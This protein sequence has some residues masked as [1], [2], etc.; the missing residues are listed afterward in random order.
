MEVHRKLAK[1]VVGETQVGKRESKGPGKVLCGFRWKKRNISELSS[2]FSCDVVLGC[3]CHGLC[4]E[5]S[6]T[7]AQCKRSTQS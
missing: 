3:L 1:A 6:S 5:E 2:C 7:P 4:C